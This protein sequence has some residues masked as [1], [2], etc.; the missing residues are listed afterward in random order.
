[1][2]TVLI[3][4]CFFMTRLPPRSTLFPSRRSS[5]LSDFTDTT[6]ADADFAWNTLFEPANEVAYMLDAETGTITFDEPLP[7]GVTVVVDYACWAEDTGWITLFHGLLV[8]AIRTSGPTV[9]C[10]ARDLAK[11]LQDTYI[12]T[13]REYGSE[14]GTPAEDVIQ[15]IID[16][17]LG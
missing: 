17:N 5:D 12:L 9:E 7:E 1:P 10:D 2:L 8:D 16:D 4:I 6:W 11:R 14:A 3:D 13:P 15:Q